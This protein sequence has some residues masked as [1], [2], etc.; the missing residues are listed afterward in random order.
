MGIGI[1]MGLG[2]STPA[3][4]TLCLLV[5]ST[6]ILR[7]SHSLPRA[8]HQFPYPTPFSNQ[9]WVGRG[10]PKYIAVTLASMF[11]LLISRF[12]PAAT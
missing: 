6:L 7:I 2:L 11:F 12:H 4:T 3:V 10:P 5:V 8:D 1:S 9:D